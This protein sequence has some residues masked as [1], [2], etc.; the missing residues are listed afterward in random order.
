MTRAL[1]R[2]SLVAAFLAAPGAVTAQAADDLRVDLV[3]SA[4]VLAGAAA[5]GGA[6]PVAPPGSCLICGAGALDRDVRAMLRLPA[7]GAAGGARRASDALAYAVFP[8]GAVTLSAVAA[9]HE[10]A[11]IRLLEDALVVGEAAIVAAHVNAVAKGLFARPRPTDDATTGRSFYSA[12]TSRAFSLAVA[13]ATVSTLRRRPA[14]PWV[15]L[16]GL[17]LAGG[18]GYLR[19]ASDA[20]WATDVLAGAAAGS[21]I[22]FAVPWLVHRRAGRSTSLVAVSPAPGG[23]AIVF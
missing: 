22:G 6:D 3:A 1:A 7:P 10:R 17:G 2:A 15:W 23:L 12:H 21:A 9:L 20:H 18:V 11:P 13:A 16:V 4:A 5:L 19:V 14:A 8:A